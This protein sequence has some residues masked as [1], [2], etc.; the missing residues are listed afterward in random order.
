MWSTSMRIHPVVNISQVVR[1]RKQIEDQKI[2]EVKLVKIVRV[3]V[4]KILNKRK[5]R[6]V[7]KYLVQEKWFII[8]YDIWER[9]EDLDMV[10]KRYWYF[11]RREL[12]GKY[13]E[14]MLHK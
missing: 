4:E 5:M 13:M 3:K 8:E 9:G 2:E 1:Y 12:L 10:E 11:R 7:I 6:G 14:K